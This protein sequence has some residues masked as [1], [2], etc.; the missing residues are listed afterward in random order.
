MCGLAGILGSADQEVLDVMVK[1]CAHRGP[2]ASGTWISPD[3]T[4]GLGHR[5]LAIIDLSDAAGQ[6]MSTPDGNAWIIFNGEI[7]NHAELR[8][9]LEGLGHT[10]RTAS[11]TEVILHAFTA[12]REECATKLRGMFAFALAHRKSSGAP[13]EVLFVRD[14]LGIKPLYLARGVDGSL[15]FGS[16]LSTLRASGRLRARLDWQSVFDL[17]A[18]GSVRQPRTIYEDVTVLPAGCHCIWKNGELSAPTSYWDLEKSV[19]EMRSELLRLTFREQADRLRSLLDEVTRYHLIADVPVGV[20]LSGGIDSSAATALMAQHVTYPIS[21]FSLG[22]D[23]AHRDMD[24]TDPAR[25]VA[26]ALGTRHYEHVLRDSEVPMLFEEFVTKLDQPSEDGANTMVVAS[27]AAQHG[28]KVVLSGVGMDELLGGYPMHQRAKQLAWSPGFRW[29]LG[30]RAL[31]ALHELRPNR[32]SQQLTAA[33]IPRPER[34]DFL[35]EHIPQG[36]VYRTLPPSVRSR[37]APQTP[38]WPRDVDVLDGCLYQDI[39]GYLL[40]TLLRDADAVTMAS[41]LE[42]RPLFVDHRLVEFCFALPSDVKCRDGEGKVIL[43]EALRGIVPDSALRRPKQGFGLPKH[44]WMNSVL[45]DRYIE[46]LSS[47]TARTVLSVPGRKRELERVRAGV[48]DWTAW[49]IATLLA[50]IERYRPEVS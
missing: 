43:R 31:R 35:R 46:L 8:R 27:T 12:W 44:R 13:W 30:H 7:Y 6:P 5:R 24:E 49:T 40:N 11:D 23:A 48:A 28:L 1:A 34:W 26:A 39:H 2:D 36:R 18:Y 21:T 25:V 33:A 16:E 29:K 14:R 19:I 32:Y 15:Y 22:L 9:E 10:F 20:F 37:V 45:R 3:R 50:W 17:L 4:V 42:L 47:E 38:R 41:S